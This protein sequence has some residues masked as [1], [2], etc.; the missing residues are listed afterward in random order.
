MIGLRIGICTPKSSEKLLYAFD[1]GV[2]SVS[3]EWIPFNPYLDSYI[4]INKNCEVHES[5]A[6]TIVQGGEFVMKKVQFQKEGLMK[7]INWDQYFTISPSGE[8]IERFELSAEIPF[9]N[10]L[11]NF[12]VYA[13]G[14]EP[15]VDVSVTF[16]DGDT[17]KV[18]QYETLEDLL[19][20]LEENGFG[21]IFSEFEEKD[22][23]TLGINDPRIT[24]FEIQF[25]AQ[26]PDYQPYEKLDHYTYRTQY[27][28]HFD[29]H[30][31]IDHRKKLYSEHCPHF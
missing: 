6:K 22:I 4:D 5:L 24:K 29:I 26:Y 25:E 17:L 10:L 3:D 30:L 11:V 9:K 28:P 8:I 1:V 27:I 20:D 7:V 19:K 16:A 13:G 12:P 14:I 21:W 2:C 31:Q 15:I 18:L 23:I